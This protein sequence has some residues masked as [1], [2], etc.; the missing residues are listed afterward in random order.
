MCPV[1]YAFAP[2]RRLGPK[3]HIRLTFGVPGEQELIE[4]HRRLG[5]GSVC[6]PQRGRLTPAHGTRA[7]AAELTLIGSSGSPGARTLTRGPSI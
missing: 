1:D 5:E 7:S 3:N 6:V 2:S 4:G